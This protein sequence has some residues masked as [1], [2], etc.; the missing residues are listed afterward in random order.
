MGF[1]IDMTQLEYGMSFLQ[2]KASMSML[3]KFHY[4]QSI[5]V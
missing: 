1:D 4:V 2:V 3:E 5:F